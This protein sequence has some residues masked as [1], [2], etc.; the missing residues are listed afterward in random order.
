MRKIYS[1]M[2]IALMMALVCNFVSCSKDDDDDT[3]T[4]TPVPDNSGNNESDGTDPE[5][6]FTPDLTLYVANGGDLPTLI[7]DAEKY[8]TKSL[9]LTGVLNGTDIRFIREMAGLDIENDATGGVL[10]Y[11]DIEE[12]KIIK[13]GDCY[14]YGYN[15]NYDK[16]TSSNEIGTYM[17]SYLTQLK[18]IKLP[19]SV[20]SIGDRAFSDCF[21]LTSVTIPGSVTSIGSYA[22][23]NCSGLTSVTIADGVTSIAT[24]AFSGCSGLTSIVVDSKN[25]IYDSRDNCNAIIKTAKNELFLGCQTTI[26]PGSVTLIGES[27]FEGCSGLTS[28]TIPGSVTSIGFY[29]FESCSG[30]TSVTIADGVTSIGS[31]AFE[32]CSGLTSVTIPGSVTSIGGEAFSGC[33]KLKDIICKPTTPPDMYYSF[34]KI[35]SNAKI[36]VPKGC[37]KTYKSHELWWVYKSIIV[38][39]E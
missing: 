9:K 30:L 25:T 18:T 28:V 11:L 29:A 4:E 38:E 24:S 8:G 31:S 10:E 12:C 15:S 33:S 7:S 3:P 19:N 22:F 34:A 32:S 20:T 16:F 13:G 6:V 23:E 14:Y 26:I 1:F 36:Y 35:A 2:M 21:G 5:P 27:A 17:F 37:G 39:M